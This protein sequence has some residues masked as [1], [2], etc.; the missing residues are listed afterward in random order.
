M[1]ELVDGTISE[2]VLIYI[3][4]VSAGLLAYPLIMLIYTAVER[5]ARSWK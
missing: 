2:V 4:I 5:G 1:Y 3:V